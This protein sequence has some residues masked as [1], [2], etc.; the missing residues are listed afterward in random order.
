MITVDTSALLARLNRRDPDHERVLR[1]MANEPGPWIVPA[2]ILGELGYLLVSRGT[3]AALEAFLGDLD[4]GTYALDA[5]AEDIPRVRVLVRRSADLPLGL[6]DAM[7]IACAERNGG[8][9]A[10]LDRR[11]FGIVAREGTI[12]LVPA[13]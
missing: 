10:T 7:V 5:G 9:V 4:D 12:A 8:R 6:V 11:H 2:A 13:E 1:A 3:P